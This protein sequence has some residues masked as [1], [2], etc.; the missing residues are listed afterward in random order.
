MMASSWTTTPKLR[1]PSDA[2]SSESRPTLPAQNFNSHLASSLPVTPDAKERS[3]SFAVS[4]AKISVKFREDG[5]PPSLRSE[6]DLDKQPA[7]SAPA[8]DGLQVEDRPQA[9]SDVHSNVFTTTLTT[10]P[11]QAPSTT[12]FFVKREPRPTSVIHSA[13]QS[14]MSTRPGLTDRSNSLNFDVKPSAQPMASFDGVDI[15]TPHLVRSP[16]PKHQQVAMPQAS[17]STSTFEQQVLALAPTT[18]SQ[19]VAP[20]SGVP[21]SPTMGLSQLPTFNQSLNQIPDLE[22]RRPQRPPTMRSSTLKTVGTGRS[23]LSMA[24]SHSS[25]YTE[26][27]IESVDSV[28]FWY[29]ILSCFLHWVILAGFLV[30]PTTFDDLQEIA[31]SSSAFGRAL[32]AVQRIPLYV[33]SLLFSLLS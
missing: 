2:E 6:V 7:F 19:P 21:N 1:L 9:P 11:R 24:Q 20:I 3:G 28:S 15:E 5:P 16:L 13:S 29:T 25:Q 27:I 26:M 31:V 30:L 8:I 10:T 18:Y 22:P 33:L 4:A 17:S 32:H 23:M 12:S 14:S